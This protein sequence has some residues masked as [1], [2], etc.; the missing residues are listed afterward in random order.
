M[1]FEAWA[2][3]NLSI[4]HPEPLPPQEKLQQ[5]GARSG[6]DLP[7]SPQAALNPL[8]ILQLKRAGGSLS[9]CP[10]APCRGVTLPRRARILNSG[11]PEERQGFSTTPACQSSRAEI[12]DNKLISLGLCFANSKRKT[13]GFPSWSS[14][15]K[16]D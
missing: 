1:G 6:P 5:S 13:M 11:P 16:S 8:S 2:D 10:Q 15:N 14:G 7:P 3:S 4:S 12:S 9:L